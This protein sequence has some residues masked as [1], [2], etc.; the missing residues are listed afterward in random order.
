MLQS[1][2]AN[3]EKFITLNIDPS[4][5]KRIHY[6]SKYYLHTH[7]LTYTYVDVTLIDS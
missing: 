7:P 6:N 3:N 2:F 4:D 5:G 1:D